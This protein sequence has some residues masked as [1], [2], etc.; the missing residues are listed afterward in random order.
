MRS[1]AARDTPQAI[2]H[3]ASIVSLALLASL[4]QGCSITEPSARVVDSLELSRNRQRWTSAQLHDYEFD[5]QLSCFCL[6]EATEPVHIVVRGDVVASVVRRRDGL[7]AGARYGGWP[8]VDELFADVSR[9]LAQNAARL[10]VTYDPT[11]GYPREIIADVDFMT[12]DDE[13]QQ[14]AS[15]LK[16]LR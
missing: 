12:A 10:D 1:I 9:L 3:L 16:P 2:V 4:A 14:T 7:P 5:Y 13:S 8:R 11:Y 15:N 6:P